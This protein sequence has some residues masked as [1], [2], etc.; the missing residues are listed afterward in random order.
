MEIAN[1]DIKQVHQVKGYV[2]GV[3]LLITANRELDFSSFKGQTI[4]AVAFKNQGDETVTVGKL[5][6]EPGDPMYSIPGYDEYG[7][8]DIKEIT[9]AGG[10]TNPELWVVVDVAFN[11]YFAE[12]C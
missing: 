1:K 2:K 12:N 10:G 11:P 9:F 4:K 8:Y 5:T 7:R 6:L 3:E